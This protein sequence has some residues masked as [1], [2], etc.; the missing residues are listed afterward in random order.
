M[1]KDWPAADMWKGVVPQQLIRLLRELRV[2]RNKVSY[3]ARQITV[4]L[5]HAAT[6]IWLLTNAIKQKALPVEA[7]TCSQVVK[8]S[9]LHTSGKLGYSL[10]QFVKLHTTHPP[11]T[12]QLHEN[13]QIFL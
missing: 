12:T 3:V 4:L 1:L 8:I 5:E 2:R 6:D 7:P 11:T 10:Q 13:S 9:R